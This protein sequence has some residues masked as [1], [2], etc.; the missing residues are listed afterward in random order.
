MCAACK[1]YQK[2]QRLIEARLR[3]GNSLSAQGMT[4]EEAERIL[5]KIKT[6]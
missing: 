1:A 6:N 2:D 4:P 5:N 3:Q